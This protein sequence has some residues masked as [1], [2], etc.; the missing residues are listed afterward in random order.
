MIMV[1]VCLVY[2]GISGALIL[3]FVP[4]QVPELLVAAV[5][6]VIVTPIVLYYQLRSGLD[7]FATS[8]V[9]GPDPSPHIAA[10]VSRNANH[11]ESFGSPRLPD[12]LSNLASIPLSQ[13]GVG[14]IRVRTEWDRHLFVAAHRMGLVGKDAGREMNA[15]LVIDSSVMS[16]IAG[17]WRP[18]VV[19]TLPASSVLGLWRGSDV[20]TIGGSD[21]LVAVIEHEGD[22]LLFAFTVR[23]WSQGEELKKFRVD[24]LIA[25]SARFLG[26]RA[27]RFPQRQ[28]SR[29]ISAPI[30]NA[31]VLVLD[32]D[33]GRLPTA[34][35]SD[36]VAATDSALAVGAMV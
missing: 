15:T 10:Q 22:Q 34:M 26:D 6:L 20:A 35:G 17:W 24:E 1:V 19:F 4:I 21:V 32:P 28:G 29:S 7:F 14:P 9:A 33:V 30:P 2:V 5:A 25:R 8:D 11:A 23:R 31:L 3:W 27:T 18:G 13:V 36:A 12:D 16:L